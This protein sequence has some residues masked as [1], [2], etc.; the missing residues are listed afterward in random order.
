MD[1]PAQPL[2][3]G[4][5]S[6]SLIATKE[7]SDVDTP[8]IKE[9]S[10]VD[11]PPITSV[12]QTDGK[13]VVAKENAVAKTVE[14]GPEANT[15]HASGFYGHPFEAP[16]PF[17]GIFLVG[18]QKAPAPKVGEHDLSPAAI[19]QR[20][21]RI[22]TPR[23]D[24]TLK[25]TF[26]AEVEVLREEMRETEVV[27]EGEFATEAQMAEWG[28]SEQR[29]AAV[30][31]HCK[32]NPT[33]LLRTAIAKRIKKVEE[34][35]GKFQGDDLTE[36]QKRLQTAI[37]DIGDSL[38]GIHKEISDE[39]STGVIKGY[40]KVSLGEMAADSLSLEH[41]SRSQQHLF[42]NTVPKPEK[43]QNLEQFWT[44]Y[45]AID[46]AHAFFQVTNLKH[47]SFLTKFV[48]G[49]LPNKYYKSTGVL[50]LAH[51]CLCE[52][53]DERQ[54]A[55]LETIIKA[56]TWVQ[57]WERIVYGHG[58]CLT[59]TC[60]AVLYEYFHDFIQAYNKLAHV[61]LYSFRVPGFAMKAKL[62]MLTHTKYELY[63]QLTDPDTIWIL[64]PA[65]W[66]CDMCEASTQSCGALV[67]AEGKGHEWQKALRHFWIARKH[68]PEPNILLVN[69]ALNAL[70]RHRHGW[71]HGTALLGWA[72]HNGLQRNEVSI[73]AVS[74]ALPFWQNSLDWLIFAT[75]NEVVLGQ[76][77][78]SMSKATQW[79]ESLRLEQWHRFQGAVENPPEIH[80]E[81]A[82][83]GT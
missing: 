63:C 45:K 66:S 5:T 4:Q 23:V 74:S 16:E 72:G 31:A 50:V 57:G 42:G 46:P 20:A 81:F 8:S 51:A 17:D 80:G 30:K 54:K 7:E 69:A 18:D 11:T 62:H 33:K 29:I 10:D 71:H 82:P 44:C 22:F 55:A 32:T 2:A 78:D 25:E 19:R 83:I 59:K 14:K 60:G 37:S 58:L 67:A 73:G 75:T 41:R 24:G 35:K 76:S 43:R 64:N 21:A 39:Y 49:V 77:A 3:W 56:A 36:M 15:G 27:V 38:E 53:Q 1:I 26:I 34:L 13:G 12:G 47:N 9:A 70:R 65:I 28:F 79:E 61:C 40:P 68:G 6:G 48:L 52:T